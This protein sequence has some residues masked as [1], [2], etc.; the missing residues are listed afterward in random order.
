[1]YVN[2][3]IQEEIIRKLEPNKVVVLYGPRQVGKTTLVEHI[4]E[5]I[6]ED[7]LYLSGENRDVRGW[8]S[9]QSLEILKQHIGPYRLVVID[10]AQKVEAIG[11]NLKLLV[12]HIK[13]IRIL[14]TGS[15][16]FALSHQLGEP[17]VGRQR[18]FFL[19]PFAQM[20]LDHLEKPHERQARLPMRMI[21]GG[22]P[23]AV[24]QD[25]AEDKRA[26]LNGMVDSYLFRDLLE[27]CVHGRSLPIRWLIMPGHP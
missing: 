19:F 21:Y 10:E 25:N 6:G 1:M 17:L 14:A 11:V 27:L 15:S 2:R 24:I 20:E 16:S 3:I 22:Y 4:L 7:H 18:Q 8:L 13:G 23:E 9:S 26:F 5:E 12:D